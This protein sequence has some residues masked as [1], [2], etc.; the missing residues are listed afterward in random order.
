M[1]RITKVDDY[2]KLTADDNESAII[3]KMLSKQNR[4]LEKHIETYLGERKV[5]LYEQEN[6]LIMK[7]MSEEERIKRLKDIESGNEPVDKKEKD[8]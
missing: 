8:A 7:H 1:I 5:N 2:Y 6:M 3:D 4:K